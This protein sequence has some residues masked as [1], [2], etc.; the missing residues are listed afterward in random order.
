MY[1]LW[2]DNI[3]FSGVLSMIIQNIIRPDGIE[4]YDNNQAL[5]FE[6]IRSSV[7]NIFKRQL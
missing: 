2:V 4:Y 5:L 7:L 3:L 1:Y 6:N